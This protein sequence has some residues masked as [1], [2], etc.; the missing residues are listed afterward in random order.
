MLSRREYLWI[1]TVEEETERLLLGAGGAW[2]V[3]RLGH[4]LAVCYS[5]DTKE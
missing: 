4:F 1:E 5:P 3:K 2:G